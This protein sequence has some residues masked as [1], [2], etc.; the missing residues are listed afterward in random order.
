MFPAPP[1]P[2]HLI[3]AVAFFLSGLC[4]GCYFPIAAGQLANSGFEPGVAGSKLET[5]DHIGAS[6]G[7]VV[8]S[9]ALVPVLGTRL[10]LSVFAVL[11]LVNVPPAVVK[12]F[13][14]EKVPLSDGAFIFRRLGYILFG[15]VFRV[16]RCLSVIAT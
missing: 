5:A 3:F 12:V 14:G 16:V 2:A 11:L 9:L 4:S 1:I 15:S 10:A 6:A 7:G 8:T 13:K